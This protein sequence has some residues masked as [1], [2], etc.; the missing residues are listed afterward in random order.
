M[1]GTLFNVNDAHPINYD[2]SLFSTGNFEQVFSP[3]N[4][5]KDRCQQLLTMAGFEQVDE[6]RYRQSLVEHFAETGHF[7]N[8][9]ALTISFSKNKQP[10]AAIVKPKLSANN[11]TSTAPLNNTQYWIQADT[12]KHGLPARA[13]SGEILFKLHRRIL[14]ATIAKSV[15]S[16]SRALIVAFSGSSTSIKKSVVA[17]HFANKNW[18]QIRLT[19]S[20]PIANA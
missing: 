1:I 7:V 2:C 5:K 3:N 12:S 16:A 4:T 10:L 6:Y 19:D 8:H 17:K 20:L 9:G 13:L 11:P 14:F 18:H 15:S